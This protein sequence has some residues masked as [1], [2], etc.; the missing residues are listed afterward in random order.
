MEKTEAPETAVLT[1]HKEFMGGKHAQPSLSAVNQAGIERFELLK[2]PHKKHEMY[3]FVNTHEL[4]GTPFELAA[5]SPVDAAWVQS[6]VYPACKN[7]VVVFVKP[8]V[9]LPTIIKKQ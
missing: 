7:S 9:Y 2:F 6:Q 3:S 4:A 1:L 5:D 8:T